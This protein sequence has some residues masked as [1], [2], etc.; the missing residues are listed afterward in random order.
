MKFS[1]A[2]IFSLIGSAMAGSLKELEIDITKRIPADRCTNKA[3]AG[4]NVKVHY[5]GRLLENDKKFDSSY[6]RNSPIAFVLGTGRVISGW[7]EGIVG[8]CVGEERILRIPS[9]MAYGA[10]G[11]PGV[12]PEDADLLFEVKLVSASK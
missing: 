12:I 5:T 1:S 2:L 10:R 3:L 8:M 11:V 7:D 6:D 4:D 9:S